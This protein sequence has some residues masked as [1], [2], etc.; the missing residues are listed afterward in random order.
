[1]QQVDFASTV[2]DLESISLFGNHKPSDTSKR[3]A[4]YF[5]TS[6]FSRWS[7]IYGDGEIPPIW[8]VIRDGHDVAIGQLLDWVRG[9]G[10]HIVL[11]AGCGTGT[12][13]VKLAEAGFAVDGFDVSAPMVAFARYITK[14]R[15][16]CAVEPRFHVG[17]IAALEGAPR[18]YD[19]VCCMDV[20]FHYPFAE[21]KEM[22]TKLASLSANKVVGSFAVR[23][24]MN[25]FWMEIGRRFFHKKNRMTNL[26]LFSYD[27]VEQVLYRAGF[28]MTRTK[29][30]KF[31]FYD[32]FVFEAVRR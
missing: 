32:S 13:A 21:V 22:L 24:P 9:D 31:F 3:V 18:S 1:M 23:T 15:S 12:L 7:A 5:E 30:V 29:R 14:G 20:L 8:R 27:Q 16:D 2:P 17:D 6:G 25:A 28:K 19:L 10:N 11:D 4:Q 26:H